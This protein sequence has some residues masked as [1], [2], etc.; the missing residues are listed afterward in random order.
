MPRGANKN[1]AGHAGLYE[2]VNYLLE[3]RQHAHT[4]LT[5]QLGTLRSRSFSCP[6]GWTAAMLDTG[7][8]D[9]QGTCVEAAAPA[10]L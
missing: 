8:D 3:T 6:I 7:V 10:A 9:G 4:Y 1:S 2:R 5:T